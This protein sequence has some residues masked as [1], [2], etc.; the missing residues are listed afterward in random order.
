M[1]NLLKIRTMTGLQKGLFLFAER[2]GVNK[3]SKYKR[4]SDYL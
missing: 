1:F 3:K 4:K 2:E